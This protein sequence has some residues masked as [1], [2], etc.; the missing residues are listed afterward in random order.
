MNRSLAPDRLAALVGN[1]NR[2]P[3]YRGLRVALQELI[4]DGRIPWERACPASAR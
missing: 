4:G 1:F 3:A 2:A